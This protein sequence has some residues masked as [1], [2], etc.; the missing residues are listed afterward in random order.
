[1]TPCAWNILSQPLGNV[2]R[3]VDALGGGAQRQTPL[4]SFLQG[5]L[6]T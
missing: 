1:M 2:K 3:R 5:E 4:G 6:R